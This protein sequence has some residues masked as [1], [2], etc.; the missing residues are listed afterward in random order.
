MARRLRIHEGAS[1]KRLLQAIEGYQ[2]HWDPAAKVFRD[3]PKHDWTSD[4]CDALRYLALGWAD[5]GEAR[6]RLNAGRMRQGMGSG[7]RAVTDFDPFSYG[8]QR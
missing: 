8:G 3:K 6:E 4:Y 1:T 5:K 2:K 7:R